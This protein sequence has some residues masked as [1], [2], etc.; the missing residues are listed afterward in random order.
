M[1]K[2][3]ELRVSGSEIRS[4]GNGQIIGHAA[5]FDSETT[6]GGAFSEVIRKGAFARAIREKQDVRMLWNHDSNFLLGRTKSG[7]LTLE[8]DSV[9]L[10]FVCDLPDT[11]I[12]RDVRTL[13]KRGDASGCSFAFVPRKEKWNDD[14]D[15]REILDCDLYDTSV[16]TYPAY[17]GTDVSARRETLS[18]ELR[19][20]GRE[21]KSVGF[22]QNRRGRISQAEAQT[23][24]EKLWRELFTPSDEIERL[25]LRARFL[26]AQP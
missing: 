5:V 20:A 15:V 26:K 7:T 17:G 4:T 10:K 25:R 6:I 23:V 9:G 22:Y 2:N 11:Q 18:A 3:L 1:K 16:V 12:G 19:N 24:T 14:T 13:I 21:F 8:E